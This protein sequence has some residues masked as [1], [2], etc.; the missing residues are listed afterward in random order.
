MQVNT[1]S[2][3]ANWPF[4]RKTVVMPLVGFWPA[5]I[6]AEKNKTSQVKGV[7]VVILWKNCWKYSGIEGFFYGLYHGKLP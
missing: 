1:P 7:N 6:W 5:M 2:I 4:R 3:E